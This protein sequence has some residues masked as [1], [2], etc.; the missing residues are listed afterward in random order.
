[1]RQNVKSCINIFTINT[2]QESEPTDEFSLLVNKV[3][4]TTASEV[5]FN[6]AFIVDVSFCN[7]EYMKKIN[8]EFRNIDKSTDV[9]SFPIVEMI[10]GVMHDNN[11][12]LDIEENKILLGDIV[13]SIEM[14]KFQASNYDNSLDRELAFLTV[15]GFL[16][17]LGYDHENNGDEIIMYEKQDKILCKCGYKKGDKNEF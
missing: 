1:M 7:D 3:I 4:E 9:L 13:I 11:G 2:K 15:H 6:E 8:K 16:H 10:N 5:D 17:L 14:A 12:D